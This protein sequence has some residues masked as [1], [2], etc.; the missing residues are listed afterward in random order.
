MADAVKDGAAGAAMGVNPWAAM[1]GSALGGIAGPAGPSNATSMGKV[2]GSPFD[3][4]GW[5]VSFGDNSGIASDRKEST[6]MDKTFK[7]VLLGAAF[8]IAFKYLK[9]K[10]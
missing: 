7:Y 8:L 4:S 2:D 10:K 1:F 9:A 5:N 3:S 6:A